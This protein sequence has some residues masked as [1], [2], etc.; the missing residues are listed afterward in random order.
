MIIVDKNFRD[1]FSFIKEW[2]YPDYTFKNDDGNFQIDEDRAI[3]AEDTT[4]LFFTARCTTNVQGGYDIRY[5]Y[6]EKNDTL[7]K[8]TFKDG[9]PA[10]AS[11]FYVYIDTGI[12]WCDAET[13]YPVVLPRQKKYC[14]T[15]KQK[16]ILDKPVYSKG[17][18]IKGYIS[19][20]FEETI[21]SLKTG[22]KKHKF[23]F[24][25]YFK[26]TIM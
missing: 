5:C 17:D 23:F 24:N 1:T 9:L 11:E 21:N 4:H 12:F 8:L 3:K 16:L 10:Y 26:T 15:L 18:I 19:M 25:G 7:L 2:E 22:E 6:A 13:I 20:E 14:T